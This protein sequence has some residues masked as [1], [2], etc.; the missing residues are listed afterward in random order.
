MGKKVQ[1]KVK[2]HCDDEVMVTDAAVMMEINDRLIDTFIE[3]DR[4]SGMRDR[5]T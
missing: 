1:N 3:P 4:Q 5:D 2:A